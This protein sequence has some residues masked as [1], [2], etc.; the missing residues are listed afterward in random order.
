MLVHAT[1]THTH[2]QTHSLTLDPEARP[3][4]LHPLFLASPA[5]LLSISSWIL[6]LLLLSLTHALFFHHASNIIIIA[7]HTHTLATL[8]PVSAVRPLNVRP[9][10]LWVEQQHVKTRRKRDGN[11]N[12]DDDAGGSNSHFS[13]PVS[14][15]SSPPPS[16]R[17]TDPL[18]ME[19]WYL[20]SNTTT[21]DERLLTR[22]ELRDVI[23]CVRKRDFVAIVGLAFVSLRHNSRVHV[24]AS[25]SEVHLSR[26]SLSFHLRC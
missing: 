20:V 17:M 19:Q 24:S 23:A 16:S 13:A 5:L 3:L 14:S 22:N 15:S 10:V 9:K 12:H 11:S 21:D 8:V 25:R 6:F 7:T 26:L 2:F 1:C 18:F 4:S